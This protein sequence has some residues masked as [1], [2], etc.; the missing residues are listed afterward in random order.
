[1]NGHRKWNRK[2]TKHDREAVIPAAST[3]SH[4]DEGAGL[5][6]VGDRAAVSAPDKDFPAATMALNT[7]GTGDGRVISDYH[8]NEEG[9]IYASQMIPVVC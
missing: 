1:M 3:S 7:P 9:K 4:R 5:A 6:L 2:A 8:T